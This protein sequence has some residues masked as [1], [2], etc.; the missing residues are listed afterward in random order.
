MGKAVCWAVAVLLVAIVGASLALMYILRPPRLTGDLAADLGRIVA[1]TVGGNPPIRSAVLAVRRGRDGFAWSGAAGE[2]SAHERRPMTAQTPIFIASVTKLITATA[3]MR[4]AE[5]GALKLDDP[6]AKYLPE[7]LIHGIDVFGGT[8]HTP[9]LTIHDLLSHRSGIPD[10][11]DEKADDGRTLFELL[12]ADPARSWSVDDAIARVRDHMK[13]GFAPRERTS[14][15][16]TNFQL[17][18]KI[19]ERVTGKPL[20]AIFAAEF[21]EPL[22]LD[23]T[24][25]LGQ[26][27]VDPAR[28]ETAELYQGDR[29]ITATR[30]SAVYWADGGVVSTADDMIRFLEALKEG[31]LL[32]PESLAMMHAW[33]AWRFPLQY[34][35]GTMLFDLPRPALYLTGMSPLW[36]HSGSTGSFLYYSEASDAYLAGTVDQTDARGKPF[37]LMRAALYALR[38]E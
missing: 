23:H 17:L 28:I 11:Y 24:W 32:K 15:S 3:V 5:R 36:G 19:L 4:M 13:P 1:S 26:P 35:L 10:Y 22:G 34:G 37:A 20:H 2:A 9:E 7:D 6:I 31:R 27:G 16:D 8:D 30:R 18:G 14:Y 21:F 33:H 29:D 12:Q 38:S 25:L